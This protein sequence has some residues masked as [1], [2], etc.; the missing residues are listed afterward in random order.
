M[1]IVQQESRKSSLPFEVTAVTALVI[2]IVADILD[3]VGAP[4]LD[5]P[6]VGD[7]PNAIIIVMLYRLTGSKISAA[8]NA[9]KFIPF[10]GDLIPTYTISTVIWIIREL[11]RR[12]Q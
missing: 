9:L 11:R 3:Y 8:I 10:V 5:L 7:I 1:K 2:S 6:I 12:Y 4:I